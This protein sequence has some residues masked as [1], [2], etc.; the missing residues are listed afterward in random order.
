MQI[1]GKDFSCL[2]AI[3]KWGWRAHL[4]IGIQGIFPGVEFVVMSMLSCK[5]Y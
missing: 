4:R 3:W 1:F 5:S 2:D